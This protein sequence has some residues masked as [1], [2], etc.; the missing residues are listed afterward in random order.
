MLTGYGVERKKIDQTPYYGLR[1]Y[2][3][4]GKPIDHLL[5]KKDCV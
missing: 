5:A 2:E 3:K 1:A 4:E